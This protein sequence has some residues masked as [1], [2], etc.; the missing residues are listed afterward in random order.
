MRQIFSWHTAEEVAPG[1]RVVVPF[2][3]RKRVGIVVS[4]SREKPAFKT[5]PVSE[6]W[7]V[8]FVDPR[9]I[10]IAQKVAEENFCEVWKV[11]SLMIPE[12]FLRKR[13]P[14]K[15]AVFYRLSADVSRIAEQNPG[16][17]GD[18]QKLAFEI[19]KK[20]PLIS[21]ESFRAQ[22]PLTTIR[23][24]LTK[25]IIEQEIY[26]IV[27]PF[28]EKRTAR[29]HFDFTDLQ[30]EVFEKI[31]SESRPSLLFGVT[32]SGKTEIY[33]KLALEVLN[34]DN[35]AQVLFLLPEIALTPQL[36]AEFYGVFGGCVAVW[37]SK[38]SDGEK[39]QE[40]ARVTSGEARILV[41]T[42]SAAL[43]P[44]RNPKLIIMDEEHEWTYKNEFAPRFL[45]HDLVGI[46][47]ETFGAKLVFGSATPRAESFWKCESGTW[48]RVDLPVRVFETKMPQ[49]DLVDMRNERKKGNNSP[50][51]EALESA[52]HSI[53][54]KKKQA[55]F[56]LNKRGFSGATFCK[57]CGH[58]F[59][60]PDCDNPMKLHKKID[61]ER[62]ICHIC[63]LMK[64]AAANCPECKMSDFQFRGWGTQQ[65]ESVLKEQ[66]PGLRVLR[67]DAD[68]V[69]GKGAFERVI[70]KFH[71][72]EADVLL[73]TQMVAKGLDFDRVELVG[74]ILADVGLTLPD[75]RS[76]E[77]VFQ[78]LTQV[79]GRAG[80]RADQGRI[81]I[82]SFRP[83][84]EV[85]SFLKE[86]DTEG[87]IREQLKNRE[88][89]GMPPF[90]EVLKL[91]FSGVKKEVAFGEAKSFFGM[92]REKLDS[93]NF[94]IHFAPAFF[95]RT[96]GKYHFHVFVRGKSK[97]VLMG[98]CS[99][100]EIPFGVRVDLG[101]SSLL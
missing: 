70:N 54:E 26:S 24:L 19:L 92:L 82:Q 43:L 1:A 38:L 55:V 56:F 64:R 41:G 73:G 68:S 20:T 67:A 27:D 42:R 32:G 93:E 49:I 72:Y 45:T 9:Y 57:G 29:P 18:K 52:L 46:V 28:A 33:K 85:F 44:M 40:W 34:A 78:L 88:E 89:S 51:S 101:P 61:Q 3:N 2:R 63:G 95:P 80:R 69:S 22:I 84:D 83:E 5:L 99:D 8:C 58:V 77:R 25:G 39:V 36:I 4:V 17:R 14:E 6:V 74:V 66:F 91:T 75:F 97:K 47:A 76:E 60:C 35:S 11:L 23:T 50:I 16:L 86:H 37:H 100:V 71:D 94:T 15:R 7:D 96:H 87:F 21:E 10:A 30:R 53:L 12:A 79:L 48:H 65:V 98:I 59:D 62:M 90:G 13:N 81:V 31:K